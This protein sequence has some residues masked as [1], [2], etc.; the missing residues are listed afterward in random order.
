M[1]NFEGL[2]RGALAAKKAASQADRNVIYQ[3]SRNALQRL[4]DSNRSMTVENAL[5]EQRALEDAIERIEAEFQPRPTVVEEAPAPSQAEEDPLHELKQILLEDSEEFRNAQAQH[6]GNVEPQV[7]EPQPVYVEQQPDP[8]KREPDIEPVLEEPA[9]QPEITKS[10]P[11]TEMVAAAQGTPDSQ[12]SADSHIDASEVSPVDAT[13]K[14]EEAAEPYVE[15]ENL[16]LEFAKRRKS[17]KRFAWFVVT[18]AIMG[19]L[20]WLAYYLYVGVMEGSLFGLNDKPFKSQNDI[21][22]Q[23][24]AAGYMT[25]LESGDLSTLITANR[26]QAELINELNQ[27]MIRLVSVRGADRSQPADPILLKLKAGVLEQISGK[28]VTFEIYAKSGTSSPAQ[29]T[30]KCQFG[31]LGDCGRK[32]FRVGLQP[33]AL[34]FG[35][36]MGKVAQSNQN[37]FI[38]ISTDTTEQASVTGKGDTIDIVYARLRAN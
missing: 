13:D 24:P 26:G 10:V 23:D 21:S 27:E 30:V 15:T 18:L 19:L 35:F 2:I 4:I 22:Q 5:K 3:S 9:I 17:Q 6:P 11:E 38:A 25:I 8:V 31:E 7:E 20:A 1:T 28:N 37:A 16:P 34:I 33:E 36:D 14:R 29:F 32:R 12:V